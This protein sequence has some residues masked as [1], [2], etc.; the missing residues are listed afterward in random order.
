MK[1]KLISLLLA[2][3]L[4]L[5]GC[6]SGSSNNQTLNYTDV[7]FDTV[8]SI[9]IFDNTDESI[10]TDCKE[11][12]LKYDSLLS[13]TNEQSEIYAINHAKGEFVEISDETLELIN[14]GLHYSELTN[15]A[16]DI[17]I[18]AASSLWD[19]KSDE[20]SIPDEDK[21]LSAIEH[22]D[23]NCI[24]IKDRSVRLTNPDSMLD[25]GAIAKGYI[26][27]KLK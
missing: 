21:I 23:Y 12:C 6:T 11:L 15:G 5:C 10:L 7:L 27:D 14:Q 16:F 26:A 18:G 17:T 20:H 2:A 19:F 22:I 24:E 3:S 1:K 13:R 9:D 25:L 4:L 8:I